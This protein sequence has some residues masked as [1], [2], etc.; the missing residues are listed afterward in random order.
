MSLMNTATTYGFL[1][2]FLHW[3]VF[4]LVLVMLLLGFFMGAVHND[5]LHNNVVNVHKL[6]GIIILGLMVCRVFWSMMDP[7][8]H[9]LYAVPRWQHYAER[10]TH[11]GLYVVLII[12]PI[13]GWVGSV[14]GGHP[15]YFLNYTLNLP[16][17]A[18]QM[19]KTTAFTGHLIVAY[20]IIILVSIHV[21]AALYHFFI[22]KDSVLQRML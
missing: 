4:F 3:M 5:A 1:T 17:P 2:K 16:I 7:R 12:M 18:N 6:I 21:L 22:K 19:L 11:V 13:L 14:A 15:P 10:W 8:P 20:V 9:L